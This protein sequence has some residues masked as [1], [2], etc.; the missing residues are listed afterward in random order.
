M[1]RRKGKGRDD[2]GKRRKGKAEVGRK[3]GER[4]RRCGL[5]LNSVDDYYFSMVSMFI[6]QSLALV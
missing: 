6:F 4:K 1:G 3:G 2:V 5:K